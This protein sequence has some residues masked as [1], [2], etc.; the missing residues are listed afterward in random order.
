MGLIDFC[1]QEYVAARWPQLV[2]IALLYAVLAPEPGEIYKPFA[3]TRYLLAEPARS[4][5]AG[6]RY[7]NAGTQ[8][9]VSEQGRALVDAV[10]YG[11]IAFGVLLAGAGYFLIAR[12]EWNRPYKRFRWRWRYGFSLPCIHQPRG[13][14]M[15]R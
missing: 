5:F 11:Q 8:N 13:G 14:G 12:G 3:L 2:I 1:H 7:L 15:L 4:Q 9:A 10:L 6:E